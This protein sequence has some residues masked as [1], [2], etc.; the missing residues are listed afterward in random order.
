MKSLLKDKNG[1]IVDGIVWVVVAFIT[2]IFLALL[3][4]AFGKIKDVF[5]QIPNTPQVNMTHIVDKTMDVA[6][7]STESN[8]KWISYMILFAMILSIFVHNYLVRVHWSFIFLYLL[9]GV[10]AVIVSVP[11]SNTYEELLSNPQIGATLQ[12][13]TGATYIMLY[14]PIITIA[15]GLLGLIPLFM[16]MAKGGSEGSFDTETSIF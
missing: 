8:L 7:S 3:V 4:F 10:G 6:Y 5:N 16:G 2:I 1:S 14:L 9:L 12:S 11:L 15:I 13:F